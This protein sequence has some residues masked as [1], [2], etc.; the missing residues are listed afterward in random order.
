MRE[1]MMFFS[2]VPTTRRGFLKKS[3]AL[4]DELEALLKGLSMQ[5][6]PL[7]RIRQHAIISHTAISE[8]WF[9]DFKAR[10]RE[11]ESKCHEVWK[12]KAEEIDD[13]KQRTRKPEED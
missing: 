10:V 11:V 9:D 4:G 1:K 2:S 13:L 8:A 5:L 12:A 6:H 7:D 3:D